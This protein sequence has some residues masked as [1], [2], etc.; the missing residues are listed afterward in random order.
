M[1]IKYYYCFLFFQLFN[2]C[3][4][5]AKSADVVLMSH[6][7]P[8]HSICSRKMEH[9]WCKSDPFY[10]G[11]FVGNKDPLYDEAKEACF[12]GDEKMEVQGQC[13]LLMGLQ[14]DVYARREVRLIFFTGRLFYICNCFCIIYFF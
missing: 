5:A 9:M 12:N 1:A 14:A 2:T 11:R 6:R 7:D 4:D 13:Q 8:Y 3:L 10:N